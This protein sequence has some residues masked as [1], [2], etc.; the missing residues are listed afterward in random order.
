MGQVIRVVS[1]LKTDEIRQRLQARREELLDRAERTDADLRRE[2]EPLSADFDEQAVQLEND[3][4]L[5]GLN[6]SAV[7]EIRQISQALSRLDSGSYF[8][9]A[10]CGAAIEPLRLDAVLYTPLCSECARAEELQARSRVP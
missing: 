7:R 3:E 9:C 4:V 2:A 8:S 1:A 6:D 5:Q 10:R